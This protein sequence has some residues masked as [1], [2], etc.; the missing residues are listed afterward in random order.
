MDDFVVGGEPLRH[1]LRQLRTLNR[2]FGA[3]G[4]VLY[5]VK[6]LWK[7]SGTPGSLSILDVGSGSGDINRHLLKWAD[8]QGVQLKVT[9][10]DVTDEARAEAESLFRDD[11][12]VEFV[13]QDLFFL[14]NLQVDVVT[15]SQF[16]H[17]FPPERLP[18]IIMQMLTHSRIGVVINDINR[19]W[20]AWIAVWMTTRLMSRNRYI[21]HDGP[22][23]VAKGF[24]R[25]D[26]HKISN[27]LGI[28]NMICSWRPL[29][30]YAVMF[31]KQE[32]GGQ[33]D[34]N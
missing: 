5:G 30:R 11:P 21:R 10:V 26:F 15:A 9:L 32:T 22:L 19:H 14:G 29:F 2:I 13:K 34:E 23:S 20:I 7:Q 12:R 16:I 24:R 4:P 33:F 17:H 25:A 18:S 28:T 1:A 31:P 8:K 27:K 3:S 6:R